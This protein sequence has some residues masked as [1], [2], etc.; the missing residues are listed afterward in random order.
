MVRTCWAPPSRP[1]SSLSLKPDGPINTKES[2]LQV[3]CAGRPGQGHAIVV[4]ARHGSRDDRE[5]LLLREGAKRRPRWRPAGRLEKRKAE[6]RRAPSRVR[7]G[8]PRAPP[9]SRFTPQVAGPSDRMANSPRHGY[10]PESSPPPAVGGPDRRGGLMG[11]EIVAALWMVGAL[12]LLAPLQAD[13]PSVRLDAAGLAQRLAASTESAPANLAG[14]DLSGLDLTGVDF[15]RANLTGA[16]LAGTKM[17]GANLFSCDLTDAVASDAVLTKANMDGTVLRRADFRRANMEGASLFATILEKTDLSG[18]NLVGHPTHRIPAEREPGG[19]E[20]QER[21]RGRGSRQP[22][23]GRDARH[24]RR[25]GSTGRRPSRH[26]SLQGRFL[27]RRS[28]RRQAPRRQPRE[29][30][31]GADRLQPRRPD[32]RAGWRSR[33]SKA[34]ILLAPSASHRLRAWIRPATVTRRSSMRN[35]QMRPGVRAASMA[36]AGRRRACRRAAARP[37]DPTGPPP[38]RPAAPRATLRR[39]SWRT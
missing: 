35:D 24:L 10:V 12:R 16:R 7:G 9:S 22:I 39:A 34:R 8:R 21:Q 13:T 33:T 32:R 23:H 1:I 20:P 31:P 37:R 19:R 17:A 3:V 5:D 27:T 29:L 25:R 14:V 18:A 26:Q 38:T 6:P 15:K 30:R 4:L 28:H 2:F 11:T 36:P